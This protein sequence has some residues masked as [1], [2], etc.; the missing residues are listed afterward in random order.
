MSRATH[1]DSFNSIVHAALANT[2]INASLVNSE[3]VVLERIACGA[4][5][6]RWYY[7][8]DMSVLGKIAAELSSG[9]VV[10]F[11][12]DNRIKKGPYSA[13]LRASV[14]RIIHEEKE[15]TVGRLHEDGFHIEPDF[16]YSLAG[17]DEF[18]AALA[19]LS[20]I[21]YGAFPGRDNDGV[22]AVTFTVPDPDGVVRAYP[23]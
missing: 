2:P 12:F 20:F 11:Y 1:T 23:H 6:T 16:V 3:A 9:S 7:C 14:E 10:S 21:F 4:G 22:R 5:A 15:A 19:P 13:E 18:V 8:P 17:F